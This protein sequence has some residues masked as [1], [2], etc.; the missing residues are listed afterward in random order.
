MKIK[1]LIKEL[2]YYDEETDFAI[3]LVVDPHDSEKDILLNI[4]IPKCTYS[5][6]NYYKKVYTDFSIVNISIVDQRLAVGARPGRAILLEN[7]DFKRSAKDIMS[8]IEF[9][10]DFKASGAYRR[11]LAEAKLEDM[12]K[13]LGGLHG[14]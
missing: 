10:D 8:D 7:V 2:K 11:A 14:N 5:K 6:S 13:E 1:E 3:K 9:K 12:L 4:H